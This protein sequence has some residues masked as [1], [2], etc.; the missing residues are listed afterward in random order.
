MKIDELKKTQRKME[1]ER[2]LLFA[3]VAEMEENRGD[4]T[5]SDI[6]RKKNIIGEIDVE[7]EATT[8]EIKK[9]EN[10]LKELNYEERWHNHIQNIEDYKAK[11]FEKIKALAEKAKADYEALEKED[12]ELKMLNSDYFR[13]TGTEGYTSHYDRAVKTSLKK[14]LNFPMGI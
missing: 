13:L 8:E 2:A 11:W 14:L 6:S 3:Q 7:I 4:H 5:R 10:E 1:E 12:Q 9:L